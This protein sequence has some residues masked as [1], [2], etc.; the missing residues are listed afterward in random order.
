MVACT[1]PLQ[2]DAA[3]FQNPDGK[4]RPIPF[5][6]LNGKLERDSIIRQITDAKELA[7]FGGVA[8]LPVSPAPQHPTGKPCPGMKPAY[9]SEAYFER[10]QDML[11]TTRNLDLKL[12][13]YD[14]ID[15][16]SGSAG[17][18]LQRE[19][20][21]YTRKVL[22]MRD[23]LV[24]GPVRFSET[25]PTSESLTCMAVSA[26]Q[27][28]TSQVVDLSP[29]I[30][31]RRLSWDV[32]EGVWR[33]MFF[34]C[35][36]KAANLVDY[37]QPEAVRKVMEMT[38]DEYAK[39]FSDYFGKEVDK[40]F[41]DDVGYVA[42]EKTWTPAIT[43]LFEKKYG[44]SAALYYPALFFNIGPETEAARVAFYDIRAE[45][46]A[47]GYPRMVAE[48]CEQH[49]LKSIG[50]PPGNYSPNSTPIHGDVL[51]FYRHTQI[52]LT[53]NIFYYGHGQSGFK[54]VSS[55]ADLYD[56]PVVGAEVY[57]AFPAQI[58]SMVLYKAAMDLFARGVNFLVPHGMWYDS[59]PDHVRIPPL[60][61]P[62]N[63]LLAPTLKRYSN[64]A[65]RSC[66]MLQG[67][68]RVADIAMVYPIASAQA[69][70]RLSKTEEL[71]GRG[72]VVP[73]EL[74]F[75]RVGEWLTSE[76][77]R[78]F[79]LIHPESFREGK[80]VRNGQKLI[81]NN[82]V[83]R[84]EYKLLILPGG[85]VLSAE[86]M[87]YIADFY[88][89]G[90]MVLAT[91]VLP[92]K[93][94]EFGQDERLLKAVEAVFGPETERQPN[95][96]RMNDAGGKALFLDRPEA[97][98]LR[99]ALYTLELLPD[100]AFGSLTDRSGEIVKA[101]QPDQHSTYGSFCYLHKHKEGR[102]IYFFS[103]S[104]DCPVQ[105]EVFLRGDL[106]LQLRNPYTGEISPLEGIPVEEKS[107][108]Y[109]RF[110]LDLPKVT[111]CFVVGIPR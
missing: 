9:L 40:V 61:S 5:W 68:R 15:F 16:P 105:T 58:D 42:M 56:R 19:F 37:M 13:L 107:V 46:L 89:H 84:Q 99:E 82:E 17:G 10:V 41:F 63:P 21:E 11:E 87:E 53:D 49:G 73:P 65:A 102:D 33:I 43:Q 35:R 72:K 95:Q 18:R 27:M 4:Y 30:K 71:G 96:I 111:S 55:A 91:S 81:L 14:D 110:H 6:H 103:N 66:M 83:N 44:R 88:A 57:G 31:K 26:M 70:S 45:L 25:L 67:G 98:S 29:Q 62:Y 23:T 69:L 86:T 94:A 2:Q 101:W 59:H 39:R 78:D 28:G 79:T 50:H 85:Q 109:T 80:V 7:G 34:C 20:P 64:F 22:L 51:K 32:P 36:S 54:Q 92:H 3:A 24:S 93:S 8:V 52:P 108:I 106:E 60:I 77:R 104:L 38:Y 100:V 75:Q 47:E 1:D 48:W 97:N 74:D 90:G 76:I 12:I